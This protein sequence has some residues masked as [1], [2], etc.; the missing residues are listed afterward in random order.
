MRVST[1]SCCI[2]WRYKVLQVGKYINALPLLN[3]YH[4]NM[5]DG[6]SQKE[7]SITPAYLAYG[8]NE[9]L[10]P[11]EWRN[12]CTTEVTRKELIIGFDANTH[13]IIWGSAGINPGKESLKE[14]QW[15]RIWI[16]LP[17]KRN[18]SLSPVIGRR[19]SIVQWYRK[20]FKWLACIWYAVTIRLQIQMPSNTSC[21]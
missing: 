1:R 15:I 6:G 12:P 21:I 9:P 20:S 4:R 5:T 14:Y 16:F 19:L 8:S 2:R 10:P 7:L 13:R 18:V 3:L 11:I 17:R